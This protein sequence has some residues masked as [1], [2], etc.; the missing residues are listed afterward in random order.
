MSA[1]H[2]HS[3]LVNGGPSIC[4][5]CERSD[6]R[7]T[8]VARQDEATEILDA[9]GDVVATLSGHT[10]E[11]LEL[12]VRAVN[13]RDELLYLLKESWNGHKDYDLETHDEL[14]KRVFAFIAKAEGGR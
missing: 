10:P 5:L 6:T 1:K 7:F 12:I 2:N 11:M 3:H 4:Q 14:R 9:K 13:E 8:V